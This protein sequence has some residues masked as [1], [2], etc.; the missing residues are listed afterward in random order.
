MQILQQFTVVGSRNGN[1]IRSEKD[2]AIYVGRKSPTNRLANDEKA[3]RKKEG[4]GQKDKEENGKKD[5]N[6]CQSTEAIQ[7]NKSVRTIDDGL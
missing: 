3:Q 6:G 4:D 2:Q 7:L 5:K 1:L